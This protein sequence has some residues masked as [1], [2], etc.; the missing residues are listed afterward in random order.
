[1]FNNINGYLSKTES[2]EKIIQSVEPDIIAL[3]ETKMSR[4]IKKKE[5]EKYDVVDSPLKGGKEGILVGVKK[6]TFQSIREVT[7]SELKNIMS[8]R[9]QY[10]LVN[11]RVVV[12]HAPQ[13]TDTVE[14]RNEFFEEVAVQIERGITA[15]DKI[16]L[17]GDFNARI[18][19]EL[20]D[21]VPE[22][23]SPNGKHLSAV[24]GEYNLRVANFHD[25]AEGK[26]TRIQK[27]KNGDVHK[28]LLDYLIVQEDLFSSLESMLVDEDKMFCP[29]RIKTEKREKKIVHSD[30][31]TII[32]ELSVEIGK[33]KKTA[34]KK[35]RT[36]NYSK[37]G[38]TKYLAESQAS[39]EL[40]KDSTSSITEAYNAWEIEFEKLLSKCFRK[41]TRK[42]GA[43]IDE[44]SREGKSVR[45]VLAQFKRRGKI[46]R[47]VIGT[48]YEKLLM[49][50][51]SQIAKLRAE[52]VKSTMA[53]LTTDD[54]FSPA[55]Y[56][57][58]KKAAKKGTRKEKN[59]MNVV[60][61]NGTE[62][63][64]EEAIKEAYKEEF[65]ARLAN[66]KPAGGWEEYVEET[67]CVVR[68]WL[69]KEC[70]SST[71]AFTL[72][73]LKKVISKLKNGKS[74]GMDG[75]PAELFKYAG[76]GV[77]ES[78][79]LVFN[80]I[81][82]SKQIP[83]QW[84]HV[85]IVTIYKQKGSKKALKYYRGIFLT[86]VVSKIFERLIKERIE[87][88]L[89]RVNLLQAGSRKE[90]GAHD[91]VFLLRAAIDHHKFTKRP[92]YVTAYD[93]EQA[94][95]SLWLED[96]IMSL[97]KLGIEKEYLQIIYNLNRHAVVT[98][99]TPYGATTH[100]ETDPIVKQGTVLGA[101][102]CSSSTG[103]YC[104]ENVGICIGTALIPSLL[105]VDDI[106]DLTSSEK[107]CLSAHI[108]AMLF[109]KRKKIK[110]SGTKCHCMLLNGEI[111][112]I[113]ELVIDDEN[114]VIPSEEIVYLGDV[115]NMWGN[116]EGL[117]EDRVRRAMKAMLTIVSL[118]AE[119]NVGVYHVSTM[120]LLYRSLFLSTM[121]FNSQT[122]SKIR[123]KQ[124]EKLRTQQLKFLKRIIGVGSY[125][126]NA[127]VFLE[128]GV[129]PIQYE[130]DKR[131]LMYL[132]RI[133]NLE[134]AD[135]VYVTF[136]NMMSFDE[137]GEENWWSEVRK[138]L[139][140][141]HLPLD[142]QEIKG[143]GKNMFKD[144]VTKAVTTYAFE[145]LCM[146]CKSQKKTAHLTYK[147]LCVQDYLLKMFPLQSKVIFK[148]RSGTVDI[149]THF[150]HKYKDLVCRGC[151][152][153]DEELSHII[154]CNQDDPVSTMDMNFG[155]VDDET[156][157]NLKVLASRV[158][159][160]LER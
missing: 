15:G 133:L 11:V 89:H 154:N 141:Y 100:F 94:F 45:K 62:V 74:P 150:T 129:L 95:D 8:V 24:I 88:N 77:L 131:K 55:G 63:E 37:E 117:I 52:R 101:V 110:F 31:C 18:E 56:W 145:D 152:A 136:T 158:A 81:K 107:D 79:L 39:I 127:F 143:L 54:K 115:F 7:D 98:V 111:E 86:L 120:L 64:G 92:L 108:N 87:N 83:E 28:S 13:E 93:F 65:E 1:M 9:I 85:K 82:E 80:M 146:E 53:E 26:W 6:G 71:P 139:V 96:C 119:T 49:I 44:V 40:D 3:C 73:E 5:L 43:E 142:L 32:A 41:V 113:P 105:Y 116:N 34:G 59:L 109:S 97:E 132:H 30:H 121:L 104:E 103:E 123:Q 125:T 75:Y 10:P 46:Q 51:S 159:A 138:L 148:C 147:S 72:E 57:K 4:R 29:Y 42:Q 70:S 84:D 58:V 12:T 20:S 48:Y 25:K 160:F 124:M 112:D 33:V 106:I 60:K 68:E 16:I 14:S 91:N 140:K 50:E 128:L 90:R 155:D 69:M 17:V 19:L 122:W 35:I 47:E 157:L 27:D 78:L 135:P 22:K 156:L 137:A 118:M 153:E 130:I 61:E 144:R 66:R 99:Q 114:N 21:V 149:K 36:W 134:N 2:L 126:S 67:N 102:L 151:G 23:G 76:D 38:Y